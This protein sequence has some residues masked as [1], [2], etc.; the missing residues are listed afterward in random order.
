M[1]SFKDKMLNKKPL[2]N[3]VKMGDMHKECEGFVAVLSVLLSH[4][5]FPLILL[6]GYGI[7]CL[8]SCSKAEAAS[9]PAMQAGMVPHKALYDIQLSSKKSGVMISNLSG[10]MMYEWHPSCDGWAADY[11]F[12]MLYEYIEMPAA[13][14]TSDVSTFENYDGKSFNFSVQRKKDGYPLEEFRGATVLGEG[15]SLMS[16]QYSVPKGCAW[17]LPEGTLFPTAHTLEIL[18]KIKQGKKF[19]NA[20]LFD[21]SGEDG[22]VNINTFIGKE[23]MYTLSEQT[24]NGQ[25]GLIDPA[26]VNTKAWDLRLAFFPL[27]SSDTT[28][29]YEMS[30]VFHENGVISK[31]EIEYADFSILQNLIAIEPVDGACDTPPSEGKKGHKTSD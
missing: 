9:D 20:P 22:P 26:L 23:Y 31:M 8:F 28:A 21:G 14:I 12:D 24:N 19:Y 27:D 2:N 17:A 6:L 5:V 1:G 18:K 3:K 29:D 4:H 30:V 13:R 7:F 15:E 10:K 16:V 11:Q 25:E